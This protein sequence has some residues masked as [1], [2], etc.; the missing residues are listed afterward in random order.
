MESFMESLNK[1][2]DIHEKEVLG[3]Q[4]KLVELNSERCRDAQRIEEL[5]AKNLQLREQQKALKENVKVLENRLRAGLCDRCMV[6]QELARKRQHEFQSSHLQSLQ[7]IF[8]LTNEMT[9]LKDENK[10]LKE[11][12]KR[13]RG[14]GDRPK[15][16]S[17]EGTSDP[18]SPLL[19]PSPGGQKAG[20][21]KSPQDHEEP[22]AESPSMD[23]RGE[24]QQLG[25]RTSPVTIISP[26]VSVPE[27]RVPDMSP[28]H[29]SNQLHG[30]IA[31]VRPGSRACPPDQGSI[32]GTP[33]PPARSS[34]P[35]PPYEPSFPLDSLLRAS[36][37]S[38]VAFEAL[39]SSLQADRLSFLSR[40]L[41]LHLRSSSSRPLTAT[42]TPSDPRP[43]SLNAMEAEGWEEPTGLL[44][45]P[46]DERDPRLEGT[47]QRLLA[48]QLRARE[49][50]ARP[51]GL[52][53]LEGTSPSPPAASDSEDP[54]D[55]QI[56]RAALTRAAQPGERH[57]QPTDLASLS[58]KAVVDVQE[59]APDKPL[60][61]S[62]RGRG[63]DAPRPA[64]RPALLSPPTTCTPS[65]ESPG[66]SRLLTS[67]PW[68]HSNGS[69]GNRAS[70]LEAPPTPVILPLHHPGLSS[71]SGAEN[72]S[73]GRPGLPTSPE[74][75]DKDGHTESSKEEAQGPESDEPDTSDS[76]KAPSSE[77]SVK[78]S[79][80]PGEE[81]RC[82]CAKE[83]AQGLQRKRKRA[84]DSR[85]KAPKKLF[86][87]RRKPQELL[88]V[89]ESSRSPKN[90]KDRSPS[91]SS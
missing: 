31:V 15:S 49:S 17:R 86:R 60:D 30:T 29:I 80:Q 79:T 5:F 7:H 14:L 21:E 6:T 47:L 25:H 22:Q 55:N 57:P 19:L 34:P 84:S 89:E 64:N 12:V 62:G 68:A 10:S 26:S 52:S 75:P 41:A 63:H 16:L 24:E 73:K 4:N 90:A 70:A 48:Q 11:E 32:N 43:K 66:Q 13:L 69:K 56:A 40:H 2:K 78:L 88:A 74:K 61:L 36:R 54:E 18:P 39:K 20:T 38:L 9:G 46:V 51:K 83:L 45:L 42:T 65:P 58:Q 71:P 82:V 1:L 59:C 76:E 77:V 81:P 50:R 3:L 53:A 27:S 33:P 85:G 23:P 28:Q 91:S 72:E 87:G 8:L 35:N 67:S 44:E 37:P